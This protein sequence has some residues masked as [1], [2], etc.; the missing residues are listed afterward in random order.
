MPS[1]KGSFSLGIEL[2]SPLSPVLSGKFLT[3]ESS[4]KPHYLRYYVKY[5][6]VTVLSDIR[7]IKIQT[8]S[9]LSSTSTV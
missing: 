7:I 6:S 5:I 8:Q 2:K 3:T 4:G 1:S 9:L